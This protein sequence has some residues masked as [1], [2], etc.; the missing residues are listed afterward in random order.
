MLKKVLL[1]LTVIV[2]LFLAYIAVQPS[3]YY[4]H[5]EV[6][7]NATPEAIFPHVNNPRKM[8]EWNPFIKMDPQVKLTYDGPEAGVGASSSFESQK[9]GVGKAT[10]AESVPNSLVRINLEFKKPFE[11]TQIAE[12]ILKPSDKQTSVTW[13]VRG[14]NTFVSRIFCFFMNMDKMMGQ[15][16]EKG[17]TDLKALA[18]AQH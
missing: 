9:I 1:G 15:T 3:E 4:I 13:G 10:V 11:G 18:E 5:R 7:I 16:F 17:L 6:M 12:Y 2:I 14:H 8:H